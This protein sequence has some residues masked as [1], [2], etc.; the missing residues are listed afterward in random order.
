MGSEL[1]CSSTAAI[2]CF[3]P[4]LRASIF[5]LLCFD[6][7]VFL[8][9]FG[10]SAATRKESVSTLVS[11]EW[12]I[13]NSSKRRK[14]KRCE[15]KFFILSVVKLIAGRPLTFDNETIHDGPIRSARITALAA[16]ND[17]SF[18]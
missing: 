10:V 9:S 15:L 16:Q 18:L 13:S 4:C 17:I 8:H 1:V 11:W 5:T 3:G 7:S 2:R 6:C 14:D 12:S